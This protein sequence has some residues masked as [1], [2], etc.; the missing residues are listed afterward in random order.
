MKPH[1][2][3]TIADLKAEREKLDWII[4]TLERYGGS[5]GAPTPSESPSIVLARIHPLPPTATAPKPKRHYKKRS[6]TP[7]EAEASVDRMLSRPSTLAAAMKCFIADSKV[8][9]TCAGCE[10][11]MKKKYPELVEKVS[12]QAVYQN[13][14]YWASKGHLE[15]VGQGQLAVF[16]V[17]D[18]EHFKVTEEQ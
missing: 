9:F 14:S 2:E 12:P 11:E 6:Q 4:S 16:K 17:V 7:H 5:D 10:E 3:Q 13:L 15:K 18:R 8:P 1:V